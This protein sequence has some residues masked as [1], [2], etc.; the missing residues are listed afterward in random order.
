M[1]SKFINIV[2]FL[3]LA[4]L[5]SCTEERIINDENNTAKEKTDMSFTVVPPTGTTAKE[6][7]K[8]GDVISVFSSGNESCNEKFTITEISESNATF[9]GKAIK[10]DK[11]YAVFP[12]SEEYKMI[13]SSIDIPFV[14][15]HDLNSS[16]S[17]S[18]ASIGFA[19][20]NGNIQLEMPYG[21]ISFT[22]PSNL[23]GQQFNKIRLS[24]AKNEALAGTMSISIEEDKP[25]VKISEEK[26]KH[27]LV[28]NGTFEA[29]QT[30]SFKVPSLKLENGAIMTFHDDKGYSFQHIDNSLTEIKSNETVATS[31][32]SIK[33]LTQDYYI[34]GNTYHI[35]TLNGLLE[36]RD[37]INSGNNELNVTLENDIDFS[38]ITEWEPI[39]NGTCYT[40][41]STTTITPSEISGY[42]FKGTFDGQGYSL[43]NY[44]VVYSVENE[45][46]V[47]GLF[48]ILEEAEV[49]NLNIGKNGYSGNIK[50]DYSGDYFQNM[51]V[52]A[53]LLIASSISDCN[54]YNSVSV[55]YRMTNYSTI[56]L[57]GLMIGTENGASSIIDINNYGDLDF[58]INQIE[59]GN[60]LQAAGICGHSTTTQTTVS[61]KNIISNCTNHGN[62]KTNPARCG[63]ITAITYNTIITDCQ[64][65]GNIFSNKSTGYIGGICGVP[66]VGTEISNCSNNSNI[67][68]AGTSIQCG[69]IIAQPLTAL[70]L[71]NCKNYGEIISISSNRGVMFA[72]FNIA[73]RAVSFENCIAS[74]RLGSYNGGNIIY[75]SYSEADKNKYLGKPTGTY[76]PTGV[77]INIQDIITEE[78]EEAKLKIL[79]FGNSFTLDAAYHLPQIIGHSNIKDIQLGMLYYGGSRIEQHL[80]WYEKTEGFSIDKTGDYSYFKKATNSSSWGLEYLK[81]DGSGDFRTPQDIVKLEDWDIITIQE[82]TGNR[83][84]YSYAEYEGEKERIT[85][86]IG[87]IKTDCPNAKIYYIMSQ[88]Y[89]EKERSSH[90]KVDFPENT[91]ELHYAA[92]VEQ[93]QKIENDFVTNG[94][95]I[96][97]ILPTGTVLQNLRYNTSITHWYG[98]TRDGYHMDYGLA[99]YAASCLLFESLITPKYQINMDNNTFRISNSNDVYG[100]Y[101]TPVNDSNKSIAIQAARDAMNNKFDVTKH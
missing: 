96:E 71:S 7:F 59:G 38:G 60:G 62:I 6:F 29:G 81:T 95:E 68:G 79:F 67:T 41:Y 93:G 49:K 35:L 76:N 25:S 27:T 70:T 31:E 5:Y 99:R 88:A 3:L 34:D 84:A 1:K 15:T 16:E 73:S 64:N 32:I 58:D 21:N 94:K 20:K 56:G 28:I 42:P 72:Y 97:G 85:D 11:I 80:D 37:L 17:K 24:G 39:G 82:H 47:C 8:E 91:T 43:L 55:D 19:D 61:N 69:G 50:I 54:N 40:K 75:D 66:G 74:G 100:S 65:N 4:L 57:V 44:N 51:G 46:G 90:V 9:T 87:K 26:S 12:Y 2:T 101:T 14:N 52:F 92:I 53:G 89:T 83:H 63:G 86:F 77:E 48:G 33:E 10:S 30:Y 23:Y 78:A 36:W 45:N 13:N 18:Y 22:M 98:W